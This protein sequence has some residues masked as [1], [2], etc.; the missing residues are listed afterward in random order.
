MNKWI[1]RTAGAVGIAG[2]ALLLGSAAHAESPLLADPQAL[3]NVADAANVDGGISG[4]GVSVDTPGQRDTIGLLPDGGGGPLQSGTNNGELGATV[5]A[6][7]GNGQPRD[8]FANTG[9][10]P[11]LFQSLPV[12]DVVPLDGLGL[13]TGGSGGL[14]A[15]P[16]RKPSPG[17]PSAD[18]ILPAS[19]SGRSLGAGRSLEAGPLAHTGVP[20]RNIPLSTDVAGDTLSGGDALAHDGLAGNG[21]GVP[22]GDRL[23]VGAVQGLAAQGTSALGSLPLGGDA[24]GGD[25]LGG[26]ALGGSEDRN[27]G[28]PVVAGDAVHVLPPVGE[29]F[30]EAAELPA[31][32]DLPVFGSVLGGGTLPTRANVNTLPGAPTIPVHNLLAPGTSAAGA[33][34]GNAYSN[35]SGAVNGLAGSGLA[36]DGL[37]GD[38]L[39]GDGLA[40]DS[41]AGGAVGGG[42]LGGGSGGGA[43][44]GGGT[45]EALPLGGTDSLPIVGGLTSPGGTSGVPLD[46]VSNL[47]VVGGVANGG[48]AIGGALGGKHRKPLTGSQYVPRHST[49]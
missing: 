15:A 4:L 14:T 19:E 9:R 40:G 23:P 29:S 39:A 31:A 21:L 22:M 1:R 34:T 12:N 37:A 26:G 24:L 35:A 36:G 7:T 30:T 20:V 41:L 28:T 43:S 10:T 11:D 45:S 25:A 18:R 8:V 49:Q 48:G 13:P 3:T 2:G 16:A 44:L 5:H 17:R 32:D 46:G 33:S 42:T 47:P 38:G 27:Q 6:P